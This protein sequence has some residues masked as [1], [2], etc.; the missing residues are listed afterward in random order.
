[1]QRAAT[2]IFPNQALV[3]EEARPAVLQRSESAT[4][5]GEKI[6]GKAQVA[7]GGFTGARYL[8]KCGSQSSAL[9]SACTYLAVRSE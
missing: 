6:T 3:H 9:S 2:D 7:E 4:S 5:V 1:M 8:E